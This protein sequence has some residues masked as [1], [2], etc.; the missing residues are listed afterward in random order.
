[1]LAVSSMFQ[2][3]RLEIIAKAGWILNELMIV[4]EQVL[5]LLANL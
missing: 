3:A 4:L 1:M 5:I 2:A